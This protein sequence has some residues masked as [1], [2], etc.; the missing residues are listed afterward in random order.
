MPLPAPLTPAAQ[1]LASAGVTT[2][3]QAVQAG[4]LPPAPAPGQAVPDSTAQLLSALM[5]QQ[6]VSMQSAPAQDLVNQVSRSGVQATPQGPPAAL[7]TAGVGG[8]L[9]GWVA[10]VALAGALAFAM[11]RPGPRRAA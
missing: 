2:A 1:Q 10:P 11:A 4:V 9:P 7:A 6:G 5:A 8:G 3:T